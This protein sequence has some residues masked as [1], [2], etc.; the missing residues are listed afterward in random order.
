MLDLHNDKA[1]SRREAV[2]LILSRWKPARGSERVALDAAPGRV[3]ASDI[4]AAHSLPVVR[5]SAMDGICVDSSR[6][7]G[8]APDTSL[9]REGRDYARADTGDDFDDRFDAVIQIESVSF[10][11]GGGLALTGVDDL[12]PGL[13]VRGCGS[14]VME[15]EL[16]VRA[17]TALRPFDLAA[18][19]LG[20]VSEIEAAKKP[21]VAFIPTGSELVP[22][23]TVP[24]RGQAVEC[25]SLMARHMLLEMGA[26]PLCLSIARDEPAALREAIRRAGAAAD[27]VLISGGSSKGGE[28]FCA[29]MIAEMGEGLFHWI[30]SAP[31]R[32]MAAAMLGN[33]P[34]LNLPG[35][36]VA[37]YFVMDWCVRALAA[38]FLGQPEPVRKT[39][40]AELLVDMEPTEGMEI[41]RKLELSGTG[42]SYG[43]R[44]V[45]MRG[46]STVKALTSSAQLVTD[47][48]PEGRR[49]GDIV[50][51]ELLR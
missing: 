24:R 3:A 46:V 25:N 2:E 21:V 39:V 15:G 26:E 28:D 17:G 47:P 40:R 8:G 19:A 49:R 34:L 29:G 35:P 27:V 6:F 13:N 5:A 43:A 48:G 30:A 20:G 41:L 7:A 38:H 51:A 42:P 33:V 1:P 18:L 44:V 11:P 32:P 45:E 22:Q 50:D 37:S 10:L 23:G 36:P 16:I 9:W 4:F 31:G 14:S 12:R